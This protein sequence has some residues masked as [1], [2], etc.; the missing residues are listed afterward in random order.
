MIS[1]IE[2]CPSHD[3]RDKYERDL[4]EYWVDLQTSGQDEDENE[5][6]LTDRTS[7]EGQAVSFDLGLPTTDCPNSPGG[8]DDTDHEVEE[9]LDGDDATSSKASKT[10]VKVPGKHDVETESLLEAG[11]QLGVYMHL[12]LQQ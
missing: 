5:E 11:K 1:F 6:V 4:K 12:R 2:C 7:G 8:D 3:R 10:R 9:D